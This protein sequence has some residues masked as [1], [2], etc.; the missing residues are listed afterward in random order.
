MFNSFLSVTTIER[1]SRD[2]VMSLYLRVKRIKSRS[3][4][5]SRHSRIL[6]LGGVGKRRISNTKESAVCKSRIEVASLRA[7]WRLKED[8]SVLT[9]LR[10]SLKGL[11]VH[12]H[13]PFGAA[14]RPRIP[15][16]CR[17]LRYLPRTRVHHHSANRV[18]RILVGNQTFLN[19]HRAAPFSYGWH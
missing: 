3:V 1:S 16:S 17:S 19:F 10:G 2:S 7:P 5:H 8:I 14:I 15:A 11:A 6:A 4:P 13:C 9:N 12:D 18:L